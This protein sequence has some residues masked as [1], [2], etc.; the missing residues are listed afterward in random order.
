MLD[1]TGRGA[2]VHYQ[3]TTEGADVA[4]DAYGLLLVKNG[5][6]WLGRGYVKGTSY[7]IETV[8]Q[9]AVTM[10]KGTSMGTGQNSLNSQSTDAA[11]GVK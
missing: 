10:A 3:V 9:Q 6:E 4:I 7:T 1:K 5:V 11:V 8:S 2:P